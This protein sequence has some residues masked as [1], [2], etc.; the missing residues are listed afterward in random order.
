MRATIDTYF[1]PG[2]TIGELHDLVQSGSGIDL[3]KDFSEVAP[4]VAGIH[5]A[6]TVYRAELSTLLE[7]LRT[8]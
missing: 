6:L 5:N 7:A 1:A 2:K 3:L 4:G 8:S